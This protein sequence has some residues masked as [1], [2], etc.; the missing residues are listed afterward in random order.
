MN[1]VPTQEEVLTKKPDYDKVSTPTPQTSDKG[2]QSHSLNDDKSPTEDLQQRK[3]IILEDT[4]NLESNNNYNY[5]LE[6][7]Q[8]VQEKKKRLNKYEILALVLLILLIL[9]VVGD[10]INIVHFKIY[11]YK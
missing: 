7:E 1:D 11:K 8:P 9:L 5:Q 2:C 10:I 3:Q 6:L 4:S